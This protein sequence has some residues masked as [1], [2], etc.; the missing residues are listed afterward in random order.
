ME[1]NHLKS[2]NHEHICLVEVLVSTVTLCPSCLAKIQQYLPSSC[3]NHIVLDYDLKGTTS[4][5]AVKKVA[6]AI[7][8]MVKHIVYLRQGTRL[9][10]DKVGAM[11]I[12]MYV[13]S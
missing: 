2:L 11:A 13:S 9:A 6:T 4:L 10:D 8:K 3:I 7:L 1:A 5:W 12:A